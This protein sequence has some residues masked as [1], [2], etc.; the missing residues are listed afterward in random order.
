MSPGNIEPLTSLDA[1]ERKLRDL[2][3]K[4]QQAISYSEKL[5][6]ILAHEQ[7]RTELFRNACARS[8]QKNSELS[9]ALQALENEHREK[10]AAIETLISEK[11]A[12]EA[13]KLDVIRDH[14]FEKTKIEETKN[15][16]IVRVRDELEKSKKNFGDA[17][18]QL[19]ELTSNLEKSNREIEAK[20]KEL[21]E[22]KEVF[23]KEKRGKQRFKNYMI[24]S[25]FAFIVMAAAAMHPHIVN[26]L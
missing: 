20:N 19:S 16:E 13:S 5:T 1:P 2:Y 8:C 24:I 22:I 21:Y 18:S 25:V 15:K 14:N 26:S 10:L 9:K 17:T 7:K 6:I 23:E 12:V 3:R 11:S 4:K